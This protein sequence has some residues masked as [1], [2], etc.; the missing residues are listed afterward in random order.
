MDWGQQEKKK[1]IDLLEKMII[2]SILHGD[3]KLEK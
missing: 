3:Q 1:Y 2:N